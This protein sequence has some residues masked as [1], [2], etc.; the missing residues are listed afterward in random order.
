MACDKC[1][2]PY[3][4]N[5]V[6]TVMIGG[7]YLKPVCGICALEITNEYH[8][9]E[10]KEFTGEVAEKMRRDAIRWRRNNPSKVNDSTKVTNADH[11]Q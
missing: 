5:L 9:V 1:K 4:D 8:G 7:T 2:L 11:K 3:P 10:R 6:A